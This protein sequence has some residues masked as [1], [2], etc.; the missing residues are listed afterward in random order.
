[1]FLAVNYHWHRIFHC[2]VWFTKMCSSPFWL[3]WHFHTGFRMF[4]WFNAPCYPIISV[5]HQCS[6]LCQFTLWLSLSSPF[7]Q[8]PGPPHHHPSH[9]SSSATSAGRASGAAAGP[10]SRG[11][12]RPPRFRC[13]RRSEGCWSNPATNR[14][15]GTGDLWRFRWPMKACNFWE[16]WL[17][18]LRLPWNAIFW[19]QKSRGKLVD[20]EHE[21]F[22]RLNWQDAGI[23]WGCF[24]TS[25]LVVRDCA[26]FFQTEEP[27]LRWAFLHFSSS[28]SSS[29]MA[30]WCPML[31]HVVFASWRWTKILM[32]I[33]PT[34]SARCCPIPS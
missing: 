27:I 10:R 18:L 14:R 32:G 11:S 16:N 17:D 34:S 33:Q 19:G 9:G 8:P 23:L 6:K 12:R 4:W 29:L 13:P 15:P 20:D 28:D 25:S 22:M 1:M 3:T 2:N 21:E 24:W 7:P 31:W 30:T 5:A 26:G